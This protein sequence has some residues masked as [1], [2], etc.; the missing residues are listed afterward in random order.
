[1][2]SFGCCSYAATERAKATG[3]PCCA[4]ASSFTS[5]RQPPDALGLGTVVACEGE[6]PERCR[7]RTVRRSAQRS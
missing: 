4:R 2:Q 1:M 3:W 6:Q 7:I 5:L